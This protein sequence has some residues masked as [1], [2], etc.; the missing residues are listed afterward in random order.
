M[1]DQPP[2]A[3][4]FAPVPDLSLLSRREREVLDAALEGLSAQAIA[5]R[6]SL[7]EATV[8]SHLSAIYSKLGVAGRVELL[9]R[10]VGKAADMTASPQP[11]LPARPVESPA[12]RTHGRSNRTRSVALRFFA[13]I[14][15]CLV[16]AAV[17]LLQA[18]SPRQTDLATVSRLLA[19]NQVAQL[20]LVNSTLTVTEKNGERLRVEDV[21]LGAFQPIQVVAVNAAV[22]MSVSGGTAAPPWIEILISASPLLEV[23]FVLGVFVLLLWAI[24]RPARL[25][26]TG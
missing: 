16:V 7:T 18:S 6:F 20:D 15:C 10:L 22:P 13:V 1:S 5:S 11:A 21:T 12:P 23:A 25:R 17:F 26:P 4:R 24:R 8:R 14:V 19:T 3:D 2:A 9:A